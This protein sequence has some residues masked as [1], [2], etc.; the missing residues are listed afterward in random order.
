LR[1]LTEAVDFRGLIALRRQIWDGRPGMSLRRKLW[2]VALLYF[3]EGFPFGIVIDALP[4]YFR[5]HGVSL[6]EIGLLS[7][8]GTPW[9]LKFLWS[10]LVD[11]FGSRQAWFVCSLLV[12]ATALLIF[13]G[14]DPRVPGWEIWTVLLLLTIASATQDI[15]IDAYTIGLVERGEEGAANGVRVSAYR[16]ALIAAGGGLL[17]LTPWIGWDGAFRVAAIVC[18]VLAVLLWRSPRPPGVATDPQSNWFAGISSWWQ[19]PGA[20]AVIAFVLTYKLGDA[21]M[22]PMVRPFWIDR[23]LS[24]AEI[25]VVTNTFGVGLTVVGAL[26][27]GWLTSR[28]G[29]YAALWILGFTQAASNLGYAGVA[30]FELG[31]SGIYAASMLESFTGGLGTAAFLSFL[32]NIC[33]KQHA[34]VQYAFLS[35]L[36]GLTRSLAGAASGWATTELGYA[37]YFTLTFFLAWPAFALL[38]WVR[39]RIR[40][41]GPTSSGADQPDTS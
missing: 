30:Y 25:G 35:A 1:K 11:R 40:D 37:A 19:R 9:T 32:M 36:F 20:V 16:A 27:G 4:V 26:L 31:R 8:L 6:A 2:W 34:A 38:P 10:P 15:A 41:A 22:G 21:A 24:V 28:F 12:I 14:L 39:K 23:G 13:P 33:D 3:T 29:I 17:L 5:L 18:L 7:L